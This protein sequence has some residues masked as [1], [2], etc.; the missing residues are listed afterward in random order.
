MDI[1]YKTL[2]DNTLQDWG[3]FA[4]IFILTFLGF[5]LLKRLLLRWIMKAPKGDGKGLDRLAL[6]I[7]K[8][9]HN[10]FILIIALYLTSLVLIL[11]EEVTQLLQKL[12]FVATILQ[13]ALWTNKLIDIF[14]EQS[15][16]SRPEHAADIATTMNALNLVAKLVVWTLAGLLIV[17]NLTGMEMSAILAALGIGGVAIALAVQGILGD[18]FAS[19]SISLDRPFII[20]D[21]IS[22]GDLSGEVEEIG[23]KSTRLRSVTGEQLIISNS[24]L[25]DSRVHN[26]RRMQ[27][28]RVLFTLGLTYQTPHEKLATVPEMLAEIIEA[29]E[30]TSFSRAVFKSFGDS[31]LIFEVIYF[32]ETPDFQVFTD[33][34]HAI[35]MEIFRKFEATGLKFAYPTQ[36]VLI[37]QLVN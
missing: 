6:T 5:Y 2:S 31:A 20:G 15:I 16:E 12:L 21:S 24:D 19:I 27:R 7:V 17:E 30:D 32:L 34:H 14:I 22:V 4:L 26:Y 1:I 8:G 3:L 23:L 25:L 35:N 29:H 9:T 36:T 11:P 33:T 13:L 18:L 10:F 37:E 28:R